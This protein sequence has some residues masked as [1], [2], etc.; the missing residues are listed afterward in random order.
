MIVAMNTERPHTMPYSLKPVVLCYEFTPEITRS[1]FV[2]TYYHQAERLE[3]SH[4]R[5]LD[6]IERKLVVS[7]L[8]VRI[9]ISGSSKILLYSSIWLY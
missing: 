2:L 1:H 9:Y 7:A 6:F 3:H 4:Q 8:G 5:K